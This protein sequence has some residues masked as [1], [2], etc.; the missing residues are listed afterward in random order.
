MILQ[1]G[2]VMEKLQ[3]RF[4]ADIVAWFRAAVAEEGRTRGSL[5]QGL[6]EVAD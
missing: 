4:G 3:R 6:C 1:A 5:A 2:F